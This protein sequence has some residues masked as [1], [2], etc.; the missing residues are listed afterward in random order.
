MGRISWHGGKAKNK[1][2]DP[3]AIHIGG[4]LLKQRQRHQVTMRAL[5]AATGISNTF[6]C[7]IENGQSVPTAR[8]LWKLSQCFGVPIGYWFQGY[9][10]K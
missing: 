10:G 4:Q 3:L 7:Q 1:A 8:T 2:T 6:I 5:A 9:K